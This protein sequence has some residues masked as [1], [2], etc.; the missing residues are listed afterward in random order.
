MGSKIR[1][2]LFAMAFLSGTAA[3]NP[4]GLGAY[5]PLFLTQA[6]Q[7]LESGDAPRTIELLSRRYKRLLSPEDRIRGYAALCGA[8]LSEENLPMAAWACGHAAD[9]DLAGWSDFN[10]RG[11]LELHLGKFDDAVA[12]FERARAL[13]PDSMDVKNNL[14]KT[15]AIKNSKRLSSAQ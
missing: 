9:M 13:N 2:M 1:W 14:M 15:R 11:V 5:P 6:E 7:A 3:A 10:N 8:Y 4:Q 12:S